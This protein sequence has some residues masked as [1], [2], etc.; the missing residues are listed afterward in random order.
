[1]NFG[2]FQIHQTST[3]SGPVD[4]VFITKIYKKIMGASGLGL[5]IKVASRVLHFLFI[6]FPWIQ[7]R[8][9]IFVSGFLG[10][11]HAFDFMFCFEIVSF[12]QIEREF[13]FIWLFNIMVVVYAF[14]NSR[15]RRRGLALVRMHMGAKHSLNIAIQFNDSFNESIWGFVIVRSHWNV[16]V[17]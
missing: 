4:P 11:R 9:C 3:K 7:A 13:A 12:F 17:K 8:D 2:T 10:F 6:R 16:K 5:W 1:M 15:R 14:H